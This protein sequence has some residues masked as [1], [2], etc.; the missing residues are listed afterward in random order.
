MLSSIETRRPDIMFCK[1]TTV[2]RNFFHTEGQILCPR[3]GNALRAHS[4]TA[5]AVLS[6]A[7]AVERNPARPLQLGTGGSRRRGRCPRVRASH[8][9]RG[10]A[11]GTRS[12]RARAF[13]DSGG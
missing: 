12:V 1:K 4:T 9:S 5:V 3:L 8:R 6:P 11:R 7:F 13:P 2:L 10:T